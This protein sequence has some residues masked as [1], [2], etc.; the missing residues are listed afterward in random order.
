MKGLERLKKNRF[1]VILITVL[2]LGIVS[3]FA[4][5]TSKTEN[6][7]ELAINDKW[8]D[9]TK[10][11]TSISS[12][13]NEKVN[14]QEKS[15]PILNSRKIVDVNLT[16]G[17]GGNKLDFNNKFNY[18][19]NA[20]NP[21]VLNFD[22]NVAAITDTDGDYYYRIE[23]YY[24]GVIDET[25]TTEG[26]A[27]EGEE[28]IADD[29]YRD[30]GYM[31]QDGTPRSLTITSDE[32]SNVLKVYFVPNPAIT[33]EVNYVVYYIKDKNYMT[34]FE[35]TVHVSKTVQYLESDFIPVEEGDINIVDKFPGYIFTEMNVD[36]MY[37]KDGQEYS[38]VTG[39]IDYLPD[40]IKTGAMVTVY[41][42]TAKTISYTVNYYKE[43]I[44]VPEDTQTVYQTVGIY[45]QQVLTVDKSQI[46]LTK[47]YKGYKST[48][49][50]PDTVNDGDVI[51]VYYEP[52]P[53]QTKELSYMIYYIKDGDF[54]TGSENI[55][56]VTKRVQY[57][58]SD[59]MELEEGAVNIVDW[60]P[61]CV[62][63]EINVDGM[64]I[65]DGQEYDNSIDMV[66]FVPDAIKSGTIFTVYYETAKTVSYTVN[67]Y[68]DGVKVPEDTQIVSKR[69]S[70]NSH[71]R[72]Q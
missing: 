47:K 46:D 18:F 14:Y 43:G 58:E 70:I 8:S 59:Y 63:T 66:D 51:N 41:Y 54:Y 1:K 5:I 55:I 64:Y 15:N 13:A 67:Y 57:L 10:V 6:L 69:V 32:A 7:S 30:Y 71:Q 48:T 62:F 36:G 20:S 29:T 45:Q 19:Y 65:K 9:N 39:M 2:I 31:Y 68:K 3:A 4:A 16:S 50:I 40:A 11:S 22:T 34:G 60:F 28:I 25:I 27:N 38:N 52:D 12:D 49:E 17:I 42:E 26:Y 72:L 35:N 44:L 21:N 33:K 61:N 53:A 23:Y 37:I 24:N 56:R